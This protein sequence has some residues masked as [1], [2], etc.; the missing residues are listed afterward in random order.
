MCT[1]YLKTHSRTHSRKRALFARMSTTIYHISSKKVLFA[2]NQARTRLLVDGQKWNYFS[3]F[4]P[5]LNA[6]NFQI[7]RLSLLDDLTEV[8]ENIY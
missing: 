3:F 4:T 8:L 5:T 7:L 2:Q 1:F 6:F